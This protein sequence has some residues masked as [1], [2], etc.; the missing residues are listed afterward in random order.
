MKLVILALVAAGLTGCATGA[1]RNGVGLVFTDVKDTVVATT[2]TGTSKKGESCATNVLSIASTGDMSVETAKKS[3]GITKVATVDYSQFS[4]L[5]I[6][7]KT[8]MIVTG[9]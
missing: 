6:F 3:A 9:E 8:C 2:N 1:T 5:G 7:A 4:V